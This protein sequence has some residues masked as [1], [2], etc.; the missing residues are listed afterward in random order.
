MQ[1]TLSDLIVF[2]LEFALE[3]FFIVWTIS[4][5]KNLKISI[6]KNDVLKERVDLLYRE[7]EEDFLKMQ[8]MQRKIEKLEEQIKNTP[9]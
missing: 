5:I 3:V 8:Q 6:D 9:E 7:R 2:G 4:S 1:I